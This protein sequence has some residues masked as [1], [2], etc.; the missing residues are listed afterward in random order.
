MIVSDPTERLVGTIVR[1]TRLYG[2]ASSGKRHRPSKSNRGEN[3]VTE[4]ARCWELYAMYKSIWLAAG[5]QHEARNEETGVELQNNDRGMV[6][7]LT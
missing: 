6:E 1:P 3:N 5:L 4:H 2:K 7:R